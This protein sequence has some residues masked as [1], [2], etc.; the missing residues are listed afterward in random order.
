MLKKG[1]KMREDDSKATWEPAWELQV[2]W[3]LVR[4][5]HVGRRDCIRPTETQYK[6]EDFHEVR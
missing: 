2:E 5:G 6:N 4:R 1:W 3:I